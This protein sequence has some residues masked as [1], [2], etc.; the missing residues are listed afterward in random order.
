[1][2]TLVIISTS[3]NI[4]VTSYVQNYIRNSHLDNWSIESAACSSSTALLLFNSQ[5][6]LLSKC[7]PKKIL[8]KKNPS[9]SLET[10]KNLNIFL[11]KKK[12][13]CTVVLVKPRTGYSSSCSLV[14]V[15]AVV[16]FGVDSSSFTC[17][18]E[19][20]HKLVHAWLVVQN[21]ALFVQPH[22]APSVRTSGPL[23]G[24]AP[25]TSGTND[26]S[27]SACNLEIFQDIN[28]VGS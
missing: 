11:L 2:K 3:I 22:C 8:H 10:N 7:L 19:S 9:I 25:P 28:Y 23:L 14:F 6:S 24:V 15:L 17:T 21:H 20:C 26:C 5:T 13:H 18:W 16:T 12:T 4:S 27:T 1:M